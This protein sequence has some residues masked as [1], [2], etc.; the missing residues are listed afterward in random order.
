[1]S[2]KFAIALELGVWIY[3]K[4]IDIA[5]ILKRQ[6]KQS[7]YDDSRMYAPFCGSQRKGS[8]GQSLQGQLL[9]TLS[10]DIVL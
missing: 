3:F 9:S 10:S 7:N 2:L 6:T 8:S 4:Y 1:M 5:L